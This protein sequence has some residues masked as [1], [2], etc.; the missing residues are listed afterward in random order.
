MPS[1]ITSLRFAAAAGALV[2][3]LSIVMSFFYVPSL[4]GT[5]A[6]FNSPILALEFSNSLADAQALFDGREDIVRKFHI[7]HYLD[8]A[9][10]LAYSAFLCFANIGAWQRK[11]CSISLLGSGCAIVAG[12]ADL[13]ENL[14]LMQLGHALLEGSAAPDFHVLRLFVTVKF[15]AICLAMLCLVPALWREHTIGKVF[16]VATVG[17]ASATVLTLA[18]RHSASSAMMLLTIIAWGALWIWLLMALK[19]PQHQP[20]A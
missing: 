5:P 2:I 4:D 20:A 3:V 12:C 10:L 9:F 15:S 16:T 6:H 7:G 1:A 13:A 11:K 14:Q 17:L 18:G 8:M 19:H